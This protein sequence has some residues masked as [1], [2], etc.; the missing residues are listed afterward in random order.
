MIV[1][2]CLGP[3]LSLLLG[4]LPRCLPEMLLVA[5]VA[6]RSSSPFCLPAVSFEVFVLSLLFLLSSHLVWSQWEV[7]KGC[8]AQPHCRAWE[9]SGHYRPFT[10][11]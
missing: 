4:P 2:A 9:A 8:F 1:S 11:L 6:S 5:L 7:P 10:S 3:S